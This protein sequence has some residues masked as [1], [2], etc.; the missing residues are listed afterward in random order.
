MLY[1]N[2]VSLS[3]SRQLDLKVSLM[4]KSIFKNQDFF[5]PDYLCSV[6]MW[7]G[8]RQNFESGCAK[9]KTGCAG[10]M[11]HHFLMSQFAMSLANFEQLLYKF[12][13]IRIK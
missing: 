3:N 13:T 11:D 9:F 8:V 5:Y 1:S 2:V 10:T 4:I 12:D 6:P 7:Q